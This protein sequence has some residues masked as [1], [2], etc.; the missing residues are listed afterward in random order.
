MMAPAFDE[1]PDVEQCKVTEP[2]PDPDH[3]RP[4]STYLDSRDEILTKIGKLFI[5]K[6]IWDRNQLISALRPFSHDVVVYTLQQAISTS[7]RFTDS[8]GRASLLESKGDMYALAPI[9]VPNSTLVER[10]TRPAK[11][12]EIDL[13]EPEAEPEAPAELEEDALTKRRIEFKWPKLKGATGDRFSDEV[14]NGFIFD[15]KFSAAEKRLYL[16]SNPDLPFLDRLRIPDSDIIV[17][18]EN[19]ELVG[20][21]LTKYKEWTQALRER[22]VADKG[23]MFASVAP[24]GVLT[25]SPSKM[26]DGVPTRVI[27]VKSFA[28]TVSRTGANAVPVMK[29]LAKYIDKED[30]GS[31]GLGGTDLD[32][33][34]ELLAREQ[35]NIV[36]YTPEEMKVLLMPANKNIVMAG[37]L[38]A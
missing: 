33:Y 36:W 34:V 10:T 28:P 29:A 13:P 12:T 37:L 30:V 5:D 25:V 18:G 4:L 35:H 17:T 2:V 24:N 16:A 31:G 19:Q 26:V 27:G 7:F 20:E 6:S 1:A 23:K 38:K 9:D 15:H 11:H 22:F 14:K 21:D 8:F 3:V 32:I